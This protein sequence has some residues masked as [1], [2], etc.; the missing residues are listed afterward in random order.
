MDMD[1]NVLPIYP[2]DELGS[3][4]SNAGSLS[5]AS[6]QPYLGN[7]VEALDVVES[8]D[9]DLI[10]PAVGMEF[11][12]ADE[13]FLF[14]NDYSKRL[15]FGAVR[16][17][18]HKRDGF[19]YRYT[20][21]C[22]RHKK[23]EDRCSAN[24]QIPDKN[25]PVLAN[26]CKAMVTVKDPS[27]VNLWVVTKVKLDHNHELVPDSSYR[28]TAHR[29]IPLRFQ[30]ELESNDDEGIE[31]DQNIKMVISHAGGY[32]KCTFTKRDARNHSH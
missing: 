24:P 5:S 25:R 30:K 21:A 3:N 27:F 32:G 22:N 26:E 28:I 15:G 29:H 18:N 8:Q 1:L 4:P 7:G 10:H 6:V 11:S 19:C 20:F 12:S 9:D 14:Y 31:P 2:H 16:R 23:V 17:S 13:A